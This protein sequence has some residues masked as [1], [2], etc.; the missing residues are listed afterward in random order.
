MQ[1]SFTFERANPADRP[2]IERWLMRPHIADWIHGEGLRNTLTSLK[3]SFEST[4]DV[5]HIIAYDGDTRFGYL[6]TSDIDQRDEWV[7]SI[8]FSGDRAISLDVFIGETDYLGKGFG[9]RMITEF[10]KS[11]HVNVSDVLIDPE[12]KNSRAIHVYQKIGF[13]IVDTFTASWHPVPHYLMHLR[14]SEL[15]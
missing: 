9:T 12:V 2:T 8:E 14:Y 15:R 10:L 3:D 6:L 7:S 5:R 4:S 1:K 11:H 13:R